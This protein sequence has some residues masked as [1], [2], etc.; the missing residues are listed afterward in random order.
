MKK[1]LSLLLFAVLL[2]PL[3]AHAVTDTLVVA[4]GTATNSFVPIYGGYADYVQHNQMIYPASMLSAMDSYNITGLTFFVSGSWGCHATV[5]M[6]E[7]TETALT[8][9]IENVPMV[10][11]WSG[12]LNSTIE[13]SFS[14]AFAYNGGNL[15]I[16]IVTE[17]GNYDNSSAI[18]IARNGAAYLGCQQS[19]GV[20]NF[21]PKAQFTYSD[22]PFCFSPVIDS[23]VTYGTDAD[24]YFHAIGAE[25][26]WAVRLSGE[27]WDTINYSPY[28]FYNLTPSTLYTVEMVAL[29][30][31]GSTSAIASQ[32]FSTECGT[33]STFPYI[34]D[35]ESFAAGTLA[36]YHPC[37]TRG[38]I[39]NDQPPYIDED[40]DQLFTNSTNFLYF[41]NSE[42]GAWAIMPPV[43]EYIEM[44][45]L[46]LSVDVDPSL[47]ASEPMYASFFSFSLLVGI[48]DSS[49]YVSG[50]SIDTMAYYPSI[51]APETKYISFADYT[52]TGKYIIFLSPSGSTYY[53][54]VISIDNLNL[55]MLPQCPRPDSLIMVESSSTSLELTW[56]ASDST[57][58]F[59]FEWNENNGLVWN[60]VVVAGN[61]HTLNGLI[62]NMLYNVRVRTLCGAD[63][64]D[65]VS[66]QFRT[67]C[68]TV[69]SFPWSEGFEDFST[70]SCWWQEGMGSWTIN[71]G[72][73]DIEPHSGISMAYITHSV[74]GN[75]TKLISPELD[76]TTVNN[77]HLVFWHIQ[78]GWNS[79]QD[80]LMVYSRIDASAPWQ[81]L[82]TYDQSIDSWTVDTLVLPNPSATYQIAFEML[83]GW[84]FG[85]GIDDVTIEGVAIVCDPPAVVA[86]DAT[87]TTITIVIN[88]TADSYEVAC[89]AG[90]WVAPVAGISVTGSSYTFTNLTA[91]TDYAIGV[92]SVCD[93]ALYST[94]TLISASTDEAVGIV[95]VDGSRIALYP[96]PASAIVT[97]DGIEGEVTV[98]LVDMNGR[99]VFT[100]NASD[101][102]TID[103]SG[104][105]KG[106][107]FVRIAGERTLAIR[108]LI[109]K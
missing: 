104:Y 103:L 27:V 76:L 73:E 43:D 9:L 55:H 25:N 59:Y 15:L 45:D 3:G 108:K 41:H 79:Y 88:G 91:G 107:Y 20:K 96:N 22:D 4:D 102:L 81:L 69:T 84:G 77:P 46:E 30:G 52:G 31:V 95:A 83:D 60:H 99:T 17:A 21:L 72:D 5:R 19:G 58:D 66:G 78:D 51:T 26:T 61:H 37:W 109:V 90:S 7:V 32:D 57:A 18:G 10:T 36:A 101:N 85:I 33:I 13:M 65:A 24:I 50:S 97:V 62:P 106:A 12:N 67:P 28:T 38:S 68:T 49:I 6:A 89:L 8:G 75:T 70:F 100:A 40:N 39:G 64:S 54:N 11:V 29:C 71:W 86:T 53:G 94:W 2:L 34:E 23:V 56:T 47:L 14:N 92:R 82:A 93:E 42:G 80:T 1:S 35:F 48:I 105:A 63:T 16:D 87:D 74:D 44:S 98:T